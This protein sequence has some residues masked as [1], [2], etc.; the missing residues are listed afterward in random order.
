MDR[1]FWL[2]TIPFAMAKKHGEVGEMKIA[3]VEDETLVRAGIRKKIEQLGVEVVFDTDSGYRLLDYMKQKDTVQ[4]DMLFVDICMPIMD[5]LELVEQVRQLRPQIPIVILSGYNNFEYARTAIRL[6]VYDYLLKPVNQE[7]M[8]TMI[9]KI[10]LELQ[11]KRKENFDKMMQ[12]AME[13]LTDHISCKGS[14]PLQKMTKDFLHKA[15]PEGFYVRLVLLSNWESHMTWLSREEEQEFSFIYP[16]R[17]NLLVS[18]QKEK[19]TVHL[20]EQLKGV[21]FTVYYS[22]WF[23]DEMQLSHIVR[24]GIRCIKDHLM[25][26]KQ[27]VLEQGTDLGDTERIRQWESYYDT[28]YE[29]LLHEIDAKNLEEIKKQIRC[30]MQFPGIPQAKRNQAWLWISWKICEQYGIHDGIEDTVWLQE[31]DTLECFIEGVIE[32]VLQLLEEHGQM[33]QMEQEKSTLEEIL[34]YIHKHYAEDITLKRTS[35]QFFINRSHLAR[36]FKLKT[37]NTFNNYLTDLRIEKAC[38]LM[39]EGVSIS[40]A[41]EMVGYDNSRYFSR[42]FCKVKGCIPSKFKGEIR[43]E[44]EKNNEVCMEA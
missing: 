12:V 1:T 40:K 24:Q 20:K 14:I 34:V 15:F 35:E 38:Q 10:D 13:N 5:G 29:L 41:A 4:P 44:E 18:L 32:A 16:D 11:K 33:E 22:Q 7:E 28:H 36:I 42:V 26:E 25:L 3:V 43:T 6:G 27:R 2:G 9:D 19:D 23:A 37:G 21:P 31:Y 8:G 30:I 39:K 17:P